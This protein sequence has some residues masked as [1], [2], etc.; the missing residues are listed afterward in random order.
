MC[1]CSRIP[2][3]PPSAES[4]SACLHEPELG[5]HP[6]DLGSQ[7]NV[8][9]Q[10]G[11]HQ[12]KLHVAHARLSREVVEEE[13]GLAVAVA[14]VEQQE[15]QALVA[16][17]QQLLV[18]PERVDRRHAGMSAP[19]PLRLAA[20]HLR[21]EGERAPLLIAALESHEGSCLRRSKN[22]Y[23]LPLR[24]AGCDVGA[25]AWESHGKVRRLLRIQDFS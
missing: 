11:L 3:G 23:I 17:I 8:V 24:E 25:V 20:V 16:P 9:V 10:V 12:R 14:H 7:S 21:G 2:P 13:D 4:H 15:Q 5:E 19:D 18:L 6:V 22:T 1:A